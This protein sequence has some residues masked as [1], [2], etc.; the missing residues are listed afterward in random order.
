[1]HINLTLAYHQTLMNIHMT[2]HWLQSWELVL[3]KRYVLGEHGIIQFY[4]IYFI[5][6]VFEILADIKILPYKQFQVLGTG[7]KIFK[8]VACESQKYNF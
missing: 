6:R 7:N 8:T 2:R 4:N 5:F 1:M 3:Y